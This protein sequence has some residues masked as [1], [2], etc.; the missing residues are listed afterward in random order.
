MSN[1]IH[2]NKDSQTLF[3]FTSMRNPELSNPENLQRRFI[4]RNTTTHAGVFDK[5]LN[6]STSLKKLCE[7]PEELALVIET[8][9]S[10]KEQAPELYQLAV[11]IARNKTTA[12]KE[13]FDNKIT[14][15]R[16]LRPSSTISVNAHIWDNLIY[17]VVT[18]KDF[19][20]KE[21][22]MQI[23]HAN[24]ILDIYQ[25]NDDETYQDIIKA[26]VVLPKELFKVDTEDIPSKNS[27]SNKTSKNRYN[28]K[29]MA[30]A[31]AKSNLFE[32]KKLSEKLVRLEKQYQED[33][34]TAYDESY[35]KYEESIAPI[36]ETHQ[37]AINEIYRKRQTLQ[38][39][40]D[41][42]TELSISDSKTFYATT[43]L[44]KELNQLKDD[45]LA[46]E[47]PT[48]DL[49]KF[50]FD[51]L[52]EIDAKKLESLLN[53][54]EKNALCRIFETED[55]VR[56]L[57]GIKTYE[58]IQEK[59]VTSTETL[60]KQV[61]ENTVLSEQRL[62]NIGG[63]LVPITDDFQNPDDFFP[64]NGFS[65]KTVR[66]NYLSNQHFIIVQ[67][68]DTSKHIVSGSY[69]LTLQDGTTFS[70]SDV[71]TPVSNINHLF[72]NPYLILP[73]TNI[74][75]AT[76]DGEVTLS[77]GQIYTLSAF[78]KNGN[79][80]AYK[81]LGNGIINLIHNFNGDGETDNDGTSSDTETPSEVFIPSGF[82]MKNIGVADYRKVEQSTYC[83]VEGEVAHIENVMAREYK[84]KSTRRLK[85]S[86]TQ[87]TS[88]SETES[89]QLTD[90][91]S[92]QR[93]EM[94]SEIAKILQNS[95]DFGTQASFHYG[96][97]KMS[98]DI[99]ANYATHNSREESNRQAMT[100]AQEITSR[101]LDRIV[102]KVKEE[103]V[104]KIVDEYEENNKHGFDNTKGNNHVVGVYRW[105]DKIVKNQIYNYGKRMM[106]EFMVP[107][108]AKLHLL[109]MKISNSLENQ[110]V[111]PVDPRTSSIHKL[112]NYAS[113]NNETLLKF[114]ASKYNVELEEKPS[115]KL[116][117]SKSFHGNYNNPGYFT[118][119][120]DSI[121]VPKGYEVN[122]A[123]ASVSFDFHL[124]RKEYSG[125]SIC[126]GNKYYNRQRNE[127]IFNESDIIFNNLGG[128][129]EKVGVS[130]KAYDC[131]TF[132][133][134]VVAECTLTQEAK[135][136]WLQK[137]FN[138]IITA[139]EDKLSEYEEALE[140]A[141]SLGAE[142]KSNPGFY[143]KIE[144]TI[145]RK[146]CISYMLNQNPQ[147]SL[148][149]GKDKYYTLDGSQEENFTNT[150]IKV[151]QDLD[152]YSAFVKFMEQAFEWDIMSYHLYPYYWGNRN[153]WAD[154][155]QFEDNDAIFRAFMQSGMARVIVTVRPG[156]EEAVRHFLATGQIWNGGEVPV[157][158]DPLFLSIVDELRSPEATKEGEPWRERIPTALTIL[159]AN[160]IGLKVEK[161]L[162]CYCEPDA[163]FND[164]LGDICGNN[165][166]LNNNQIGQTA[167]KWMEI[168]FNEMNDYQTIN[169]YDD[170]QAFPLVYK[171]LGNTINID[172]DATW[173][174]TDS[175]DK[176]YQ[177][178]AD[179]LSM[180]DGIEAYITGENGITFKVDINKI[181][182]FSFRKP[183]TQDDFELFRFYI[184]T[185]ETY[186][187][188]ISPT[189]Q[190]SQE[191]ILAKGGQT[192]P[193]EEY[194]DKVPLSKFLV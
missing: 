9:K 33:Y 65:I 185:E 136:A 100:E 45:V 137:T 174:G 98:F 86:E 95:K 192:I 55:L 76:L 130:Y 6:E 175:S 131:G 73:N 167:E 67:F 93:H 115:L 118:T 85:R 13:E 105:V 81:L 143:R 89:E 110:L 61:L 152:Q 46:L 39:R 108:P 58:N 189:G 173:Q 128:I 134:S 184:D 5:L 156:F 166:E 146:N 77:D 172:R 62:S 82:G 187:K 177:A 8:E 23:I 155:Y 84:E 101:A 106:F 50:V 44:G 11:W 70:S 142:M 176:I 168:T 103:R 117:V 150:A 56:A 165:F 148:T 169:Q 178:L 80:F 161:A 154:L 49:P 122:K 107:E 149:F 120:A 96:G 71:S 160:S 66:R 191:R 83:Y 112:E 60:E 157:I 181:K 127:K 193:Q 88:S 1:N 18:Q 111:K 153:N 125:V 41:Y 72:K 92:T 48:I 126:I 26:K 75:S 188:I 99:G 135:N 121:D 38:N 59:I 7:K 87:T 79:S 14:D 109:G 90:T 37:Q 53:D 164:D 28:V 43:D 97:E 74:T 10:L 16:N 17:Q 21:I 159:Q 163:T 63:V 32:N 129:R 3:R 22:L 133:L 12:T 27:V 147:A 151:D 190:Y 180:L 35:A 139:Y 194:T 124:N 104:D 40:I 144:N 158:D 170:E 51:F 54:D 2:T 20:A 179:E 162:P 78:L 64:P 140:E 15:Y 25:N 34:Q 29:G 132:A 52:P 57:S 141:K 182:N 69:T 94:Q 183:G 4:F 113:L 116:S 114:W 42:L 138:A 119:G 36:Q 47:D 145:L 171:C 68:N 24:H 19:Y 91:T 102:T 30:F 31:E 186:L 123:K